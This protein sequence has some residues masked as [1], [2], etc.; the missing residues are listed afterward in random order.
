MKHFS[1]LNSLFIFKR[2]L[3]QLELFPHRLGCQLRFDEE[4]LIVAKDANRQNE[5]T[6]HIYDPRNPLNKRRRGEGVEQEGS[7]KKKGRQA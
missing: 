4:R 6:Y 7:S 5:D 2:V 3:Y 1:V